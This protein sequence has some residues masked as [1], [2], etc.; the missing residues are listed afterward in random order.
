[1]KTVIIQEMRFADYR[2]NRGYKF[3]HEAR[4]HEGSFGAS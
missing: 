2:A 1:M 4:S 3:S